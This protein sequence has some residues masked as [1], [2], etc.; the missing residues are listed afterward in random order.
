MTKDPVQA[1]PT[2]IIIDDDEDVRSSLGSLLRSVGMQVR[3]FGSTDEFLANPVPDAPCC[4]VLDVSLPGTNGLDFQAG[5][6]KSG[7]HIPTVFITGHGDIPMTVRAMKAGAMEFLAKPFDD[8]DL[9]NAVRAAIEKSLKDQQKN[10]WQDKI[11]KD[12]LNLTPREREIIVLV[13]SGLMN[14]QIAAKLGVTEITVKVHRGNV[15]RKMGA[16]SLADLVRISD[17]LDLPR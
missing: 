13:A 12:F 4:L 14:K 6:E 11:R 16:K 17:G 8:R 2:V 7:V 3:L 9:L 1:P 5:L 10:K 15:M